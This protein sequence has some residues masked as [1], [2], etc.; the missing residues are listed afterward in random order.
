MSYE[1]KRILEVE[2]NIVRIRRTVIEREVEA[3][4][5]LSALGRSTP[6]DTGALPQG[7]A[8]LRGTDPGDANKSYQLF[9]IERPPGPYCLK[10]RVLKRGASGA[11]PKDEDN[12][13]DLC[14]S[15]PRVLWIYRFTKDVQDGVYLIGLTQP[16]L[17]AYRE[18]RITTILM[19]NIHQSG[20]D[21]FCVGNDIQIPTN[22]P[23][24]KRVIWL[25]NNLQGSVW[26]SDL[27]PAYPA[28]CGVDHLFDWHEKTAKDSDYQ[29]KM[30]FPPHQQK[31]LGGLLDWL[32]H[33]PNTH[34][35]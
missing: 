7:G 27:M 24:A 5:F 11:A 19:P 22:L 6:F 9:C 26:N 30:K 34:N 1:D 18:Q 15:W 28:G 20:N 8:Y 2:G 31:T 25:H 3:S 17:E 12:M 14:L 33:L 16:L 35:N 4:E 10:Y 21:Y 23:M 29:S 13:T 32:L